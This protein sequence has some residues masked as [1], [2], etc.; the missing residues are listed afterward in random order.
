M[1][2]NSRQRN[3][4]LIIGRQ[5]ARVKRIRKDTNELKKKKKKKLMKWTQ[6]VQDRLQWKDIVEKARI[7]RSC[8]AIEKK[9]AVAK[10]IVSVTDE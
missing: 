2:K 8:S 1:L 6:Q 7:Y 4:R 9:K 5:P 3:E 10:A